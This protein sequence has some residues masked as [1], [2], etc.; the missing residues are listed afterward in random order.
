MKPNK[1]VLDIFFSWGNWV[2]GGDAKKKMDFDYYM[3]WVIFI[4]FLIVALGNLRTFALS[5]YA[6]HIMFSSI[7]WFLFSLAILWFQY[8][9]L[10]SFWVYRESIKNAQQQSNKVESQ[11]ESVEEMLKGGGK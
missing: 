10:R 4:A 8:N 6:E 2:T 3:L 11:I 7:G 9:N 5:F 1:G